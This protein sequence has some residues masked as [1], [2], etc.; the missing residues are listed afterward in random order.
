MPAR[1]NEPSAEYQKKLELYERLVAT[2]PQVE[3]KGDTMPY[4]SING[5]MYSLFTKEAT[6]ALRLPADVREAFLAKHKTKLTEQYGAVMREYVDVPDS[7]LANTKALKPYF[8][9]SYE[10]ARGLRVKPSRAKK[11]R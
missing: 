10:Y 5:N 6:L 9:A 11:R 4:T 8:D 2:N 7:L 3:R 1:A